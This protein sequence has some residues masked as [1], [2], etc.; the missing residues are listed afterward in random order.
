MFEIKYNKIPHKE[1]LNDS[2]IDPKINK[3]IET[4][5]NKYLKKRFKIHA[6]T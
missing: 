6:P 2:M 5:V 1:K 3:K 4:K